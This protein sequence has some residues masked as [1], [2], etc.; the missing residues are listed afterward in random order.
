MTL[1]NNW[2]TQ[3]INWMSWI[4]RFYLTFKGRIGQT[5]KCTELEKDKSL[6]EFLSPVLNIFLK[7]KPALSRNI[8]PISQM[9]MALG[10]NCT[11]SH[12]NLL[13]R[14]PGDLK[15]SRQNI[16]YSW[17]FLQKKANKTEI[18][19]EDKHLKK[20][21]SWKQQIIQKICILKYF[22]LIGYSIAFP[23][24]LKFHKP[25]NYSKMIIYLLLRL[26]VLESAHC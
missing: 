2:S 14:S 15:A 6:K 24:I 19:S 7:P 5:I 17:T 18:Y 9:A 13:R 10:L 21:R 1:E 4:G 8:L 25:T 22:I 20:Y 16:N 3:R 11:T 26:Q 23:T 12:F